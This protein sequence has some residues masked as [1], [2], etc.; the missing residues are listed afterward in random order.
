MKIIISKETPDKGGDLIATENLIIILEDYKMSNTPKSLRDRIILDLW[1]K[2]LI[3][4]SNNAIASNMGREKE[5]RTF[6]LPFEPDF[7]R[8]FKEGGE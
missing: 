4:I 2:Y 1:I 7:S 8:I 6:H 5:K 3:N